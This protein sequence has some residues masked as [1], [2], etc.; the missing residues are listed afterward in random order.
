M[1]KALQTPFSVH[2]GL[3]RWRAML[4][5]AYDVADTAWRLCLR[6]AIA[7]TATPQRELPAIS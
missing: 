5:L 6:R 4:R 1:W 2:D 7:P 3:M